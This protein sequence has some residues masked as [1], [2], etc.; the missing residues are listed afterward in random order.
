MR[1]SNNDGDR[2]STSRRTTRLSRL[3]PYPAM[4]ADELA[5]SLVGRHVPPEA[6]VIDPFCGSGQLLAAAEAAAIRVGIDANPLA[7]LLTKAKLAPARDT[8]IAPFVAE[9]AQARRTV[10]AGPVHLFPDRKVEWFTPTALVELQRIAAWINSLKLEEPERLL[11]SSALSATVREASFARSSGWKLHRLDADAR[12]AFQACPWERFEERLRYCLAE[13]RTKRAVQGECYVALQDARSLSHP[14]NLAWT[15]APYDVVLTS[16]PYGD[17]RTTVQYG[18]ASSLCLSIVSQI[19]EM[20]HLAL[21]GRQI[22]SECLGGRAR[23][24]LLPGDVKKYW[25]G[26]AR[27]KAARSVATFLADYDEV[28]DAIAKIVKPEGK[29]ILVVGRRSTGG[30]RLK[31]DLFTVDRLKARGFDLVSRELRTLQQKRIPWKINRFGRSPLENDRRRGLLKR[32]I[33]LRPGTLFVVARRPRGV[34]EHT[35]NTRFGSRGAYA[36][37]SPLAGRVSEPLP[38]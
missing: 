4:V 27:G 14:G 8:V 30:Y 28:C 17:S 10:A 34:I 19:E 6:K 29:A 12:S 9:I 11:V 7:W 21:P 20:E 15:H 24:V 31:L 3:H 25:A 1:V 16:P 22:D 5:L 18:A 38:G 37:F 2:K 33:P 32:L 26:A 23:D 35:A 13:L 36:R